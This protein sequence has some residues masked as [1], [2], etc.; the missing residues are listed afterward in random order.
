M[1]LRNKG[2]VPFPQMG[3]GRFLCFNLSDIAELEQ[4]YGIGE[5]L[6]TIDANLIEGSGSTTLKCL[7]IGLKE[8]K[9]GKRVRVKFDVD[10][11]DFPLTESHSLIMD[12]LCLAI[13]NM[14]YAETKAEIERRNKE[15][16]EAA[17]KLSE[18]IKEGEEDPLSVSEAPSATKQ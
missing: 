8:R 2:E 3:E 6:A 9:D 1:A 10:D 16:S 7:E 11:I 4:V 13:G 12:A 15:V 17:Q 5:Y 14:D 18:E